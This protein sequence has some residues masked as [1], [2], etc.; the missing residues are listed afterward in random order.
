MKITVTT[1]TDSVFFLDVSE[2]LELEN[3]KA[4]CEVE[5]GLPSAEIII[6]FNG[7]PLLDD[8]K[9]LKHFGIKDGDCVIL[10]R[11]PIA[12]SAG[13]PAVGGLDAA[14]SIGGID[15]SNILIP[16]VGGS[17]TSGLAP[18]YR[19]APSGM[20]YSES[21]EFNVNYDDDPAAVRQMFLSN[22]ESLSLLKQNN[23]R[24]ADAL[25]SGNLENF[26]KILRE[27]IDLRKQRQMQRLRM[28]NADPFDEEAQR[29]IAEEI[30]QKNIQD[31]MA[32]AIEY[33]PEIFGTVTMLYIN[34]KVNGVPVKAFVDSGAQTTIMS[35]GCAERCNVNRLIDTRWNG[36]AKGVGTQRIIGRIHMVQLQ[37]ESDHLTSS[38]SVLE[39]QPMDMLLGLDMLKRHQCNI[40]LQRNVLRIGTTGTETQ[41]LPENELPD[42]ARLTG[43]SEEEL[44]LLEK[45]ASEAE[46]RDIQQAIE[47][48]K[49]DAAS[50]SKRSQG[51][52]SN[53]VL[54]NDSFTESDV[55]D[56]VRLGYNRDDV[57]AE[58]RRHNGNKTQAT[59]AL[60]AKSLRF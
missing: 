33:N 54:S 9:S 50:T 8:K 7:A 34:C 48:S 45:S 41:F 57:I 52:T 13:A 18:G 28:L 25:L 11:L 53:S 17:N 46:S 59:A 39:K 44:K 47:Q 55:A 43:N 5:S 27:Q 22:P 31:N 1:L 15:F 32:A 24:L 23:P 58:L 20:D 56:L 26:A 10:Q 3:F 38:F 37:I 36:V 14:S 49:Q 6:V 42:C 19:P 30:K 51:G 35:A 60:I 29:L 21:D 12:R 40:D 4:F 16:G 2:E